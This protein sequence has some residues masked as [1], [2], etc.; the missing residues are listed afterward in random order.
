MEGWSASLVLRRWP[1]EVAPG[2]LGNA[3]ST[4]L[5]VDVGIHLQP[6]DAAWIA[7]K[8]KVQQSLHQDSDDAGDMLSTRDARRLREDLIARKNRPVSV[9]I[10]FTVR[11][12]DKV[13]LAQ[14]VNTLTHEIG[15]AL[16]DVRPATF[17][18]DRGLEATLPTGLNRLLGSWRTLDCMSVASTW[19]FQP[20]TINHA[21]G[22][23]I[24]T[25]NGMLVKLD[26][27]DP[28]LESFGGILLAKVGMGKS[29]FLKLLTRR[30][31]N[32][33][34]LIVEQR[35][36]AE[37]SGVPG[38]TTLN[39]AEVELSERA[40]HLRTFVANLWEEAKRDSR[41][42]LLVLDELWSLLRDP[43]LAALIEEIARIGRHYYL[44]LW[45]ATQQ[46]R[47]LL[48]SGR[49]VLD[50]AAIRIYLKQHDR[51]LDD[52]CDAVGLSIPAR[53]FL[54]G[55][56]RGQAL[57]DVSGMLV[58]V[59]I[60]ASQ[61]EHAMITTD[62][63]E[64]VLHNAPKVLVSLYGMGDMADDRGHATGVRADAETGVLADH[65]PAV[66]GPWAP[67]LE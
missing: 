63:R 31:H 48:D 58:P 25:S 26:P 15:L 8:L 33:E 3:L 66:A 14:R 11:A 2:W 22:A 53:R 45:I 59:D 34:V 18:H 36:P 62:P 13:L 60:Q 9:A 16:G 51:D 20:A 24:G 37:Y 43:A 1:R 12:P 39:L 10:A 64:R 56:A 30:L 23:D 21:N 44:S 29:Y 61:T 27:F 54:R 4:D 42:R 65:R 35:T 47:E 46:V 49:A 67:S 38:A 57:L 7:R 50:N 6:Q 28:S 32:V 55:A 41:P 19:P 52:L 5:P 17:E 40:H